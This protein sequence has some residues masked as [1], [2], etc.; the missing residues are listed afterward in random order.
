MSYADRRAPSESGPGRRGALGRS[1]DSLWPAFGCRGVADPRRPA[2]LPPGAGLVDGTARSGDDRV[3]HPDAAASRS[4]EHTS[5][6]QSLMRISYAV[7]CLKK[8]KHT[9]IILQI[10]IHNQYYRQK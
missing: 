3:G 5:D 7:F 9:Q 1:D 10:D 8:K 2:Q 4:E 6:L